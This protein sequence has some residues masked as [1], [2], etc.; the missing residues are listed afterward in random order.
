M[1]R[2]TVPERLQR[3]IELV[4]KRLLKLEI[5]RKD[6]LEERERLVAAR[7]A[8]APRPKQA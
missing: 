8:L 6:M 4:D 7:D 3:E 5:D 2:M 1:G